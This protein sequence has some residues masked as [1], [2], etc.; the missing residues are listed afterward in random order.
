M[1][2]VDNEEM[3]LGLEEMSLTCSQD[4]GAEEEA[5]GS[6]PS[7][8]SSAKK[9]N[10]GEEEKCY[11]ILEGIS[12]RVEKKLEPNCLEPVEHIDDLPVSDQ[13]LKFRVKNVKMLIYSILL[14]SA[15]SVPESIKLSKEL[16][17]GSRSSCEQ[18]VE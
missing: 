7:K 14:I 2:N 18:A 8:G 17:T 12:S 11:G 6:S 16:G 10:V 13:F 4:F 5:S 9:V 15:T 1:A 3:R